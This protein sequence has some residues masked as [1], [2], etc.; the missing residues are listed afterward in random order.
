MLGKKGKG[1]VPFIPNHIMTEIAVAFFVT[2]VIFY[3]A[4]FWPRGLGAPANRF[5][6]PPHIKPEWYFLWMYQLLR[7]LPKLVG[8]LVPPVLLVVFL[9][10]PWLD[11]S[12]ERHPRRRPLA[13]ALMAVSVVL[14]AVLTIQGMQ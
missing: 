10:V 12:P 3:L 11:R 9:L 6:T 13:S 4:G 1:A 7:M 5:V 2:G 8:I 14:V